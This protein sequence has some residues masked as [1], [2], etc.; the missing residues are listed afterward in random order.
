M[1]ALYGKLYDIGNYED[2]KSLVDLGDYYCALPAVSRSLYAAFLNSNYIRFKIQDA[3]HKLLPLAV[4]LRNQILFRDCLIWTVSDWDNNL[5]DEIEDPKLKS[6]A[7]RAYNAIGCQVAKA[8]QRV[9]QAQ[10]KADHGSFK[11]QSISRVIDAAKSE[12]FI[13]DRVCIP[14]YLRRIHVS[15][16]P[17]L[18]K[19]EISNWAL[20]ENHLRLNPENLQA[21]QIPDHQD[22][23]DAVAYGRFL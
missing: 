20:M 9:Q 5:I 6:I 21:G 23:E 18:R 12:C 1:D 17:E 13:K 3:A 4:K 19:L 10:T 15:S 14:A 8:L 16:Q 7:R 22:F 2:L 11:A